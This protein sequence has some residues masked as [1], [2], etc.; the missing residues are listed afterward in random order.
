MLSEPTLSIFVPAYNAADTLESVV[1]RI[2]EDVWERVESFW[3]INDGSTDETGHVAYR[4]AETNYRICAVH[5]EQNRGYGAV[6]KKALALC[7]ND[8][9]D[10][11]L[12]LHAD[13]QYPPESIRAFMQH[14]HEG[15]YDILQGS[16][17][18]SGT[19]ISGGMPLYKFFAGKALTF[20]ENRVFGLKM[21]DY[22]SGYLF[23]SRRALETIDFDRF[24]ASFDFDLEMI[25][26]ARTAGLKI[27]ELPIPTR[28]GEE[29]SYLNPIGYGF[30]VLGV[31]GK[32]LIGRYRR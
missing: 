14:M 29:M 32:Y 3:I 17:I 31:M 6:V 30:R 4:L 10:M 19:A 20:F 26:A 27:G 24:S 23:Y 15:R 2:A 11:A 12:C 25:A 8:A 28:Y 22:H 21:T 18:A 9:C 7:R 5:L 16:R 1:R 13:G